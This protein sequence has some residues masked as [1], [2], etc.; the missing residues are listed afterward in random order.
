MGSRFFEYSNKNSI[1]T[2]S[3]KVYF[4]S[5]SFYQS[6]LF[7]FE[8]IPKDSTAYSN[9]YKLHNQYT[10]VHKKFNISIK[11]D[12]IPLSIKDKIYIAYS[13]NNEKE[14]YYLG[15]DNENSFLK[16]KSRQLGYFKIMADTIPPEIKIVNFKEGKNISKQKTLKVKI[17]DKQTGIKTYRATLN[18]NWILMEYDAKKNLLTYNYDDRIEAGN[19]NFKIIVEDLLNNSTEYSC[20][21]SY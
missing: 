3:L 8:I 1:E 6:F 19:N 2:D 17:K 13:T 12:S 9:T 18:N 16:T 4:S 10:P 20:N 5:N 14:Y 11:P 15:S 21:I 7:D